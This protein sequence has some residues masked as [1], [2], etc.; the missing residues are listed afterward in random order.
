MV[1]ANGKNLFSTYS[2]LFNLDG[3]GVLQ[4]TLPLVGQYSPSALPLLPAQL[5]DILLSLRKA[6]PSEH[7]NSTVLSKNLSW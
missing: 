1:T 4:L 6:V 2:T 7:Y 3:S 5:R